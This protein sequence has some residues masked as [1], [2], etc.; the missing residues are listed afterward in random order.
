VGTS[1]NLREV[2]GTSWVTGLLWWVWV[3]P[4]HKKCETV[5][6]LLLCVGNNKYFSLRMTDFSILWRY[7]TIFRIQPGSSRFVRYQ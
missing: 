7:F 4:G 6:S 5:K 2:A 1:Q 3:D